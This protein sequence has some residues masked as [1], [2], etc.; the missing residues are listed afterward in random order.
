MLTCAAAATAAALAAG[1]C[2]AVGAEVLTCA[3]RGAA[4]AAESSAAREAEAGDGC[5]AG[6]ACC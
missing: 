1:G 2:W 6:L 3:A 4:T 5:P